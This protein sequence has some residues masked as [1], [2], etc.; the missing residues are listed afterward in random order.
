M[1]RRNFFKTAA[2]GGLA[3]GMSRGWL[4]SDL[5]A[6][7][8]P[9][10]TGGKAPLALAK[11]E[12]FWQRVRR[13]FAP[14]PDFVNLEYGYFCPSALSTLETTVRGARDINSGGSYFMRR[15][16]HDELEEA[17]TDLAA[18]A[19]VST[20]EICITRNTTESMNIIVN[21]LDMERG[22][23]IVYSDQDYGSMVESMEQ[24]AKRYGVVLKQVAIPLDP[25]SDDEIVAIW[26]RAI[27]PR[28]KLLHVTHLINITGHILPVRKICD[29]AHRHGVE[30]LVDSAHAFAHIDYKIEDLGCDYLGTS[31]HKWLCS[32]VGLGMLYVKREK[33]EKIWPLMADTGKKVDDI[34]KLEELGTRPYNHHRGLRTAIEF[35]K[36]IGGKAKEERLRYL[37]TYW[38]QDF[39]DHDRIYFNTPTDPSRYVAIS[40]VG[41]RG[42]TPKQLGDFLWDKH[43]ILIA[44]VDHPVVKGVRV[45]PGLPT[46]LRHLDLMKVAMEDAARKL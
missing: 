22:D 34:R 33:I 36:Q 32:P 31:L 3:V 21:G 18:L 30:V 5:S 8:G 29:M 19:G 11:D 17:R 41:V 15:E 38:T 4:A 14:R 42:A 23:E 13:E 25:K 12:L 16:M 43:N 45:T 24:K 26:E 7:A 35:H 10:D 44:G 37:N 2:V 46:P 28:T 39:R 27:T 40:N 20:E 9:I 6:A 1:L